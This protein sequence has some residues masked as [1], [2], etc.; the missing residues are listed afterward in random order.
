MRWGSVLSCVMAMTL[1]VSA[2]H[3]ATLQQEYLDIYI[4][5]SDSER[6]EKSVIIA[7]R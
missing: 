2:A 7:A 6:L 1:A 4:K 3:G 5:L